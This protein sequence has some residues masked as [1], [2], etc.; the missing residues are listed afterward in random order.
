MIVLLYEVFHAFDYVWLYAV[1]KSRVRDLA[2]LLHVVRMPE[3]HWFVTASDWDKMDD[4]MN[5][6]LAITFPAP[7]QNVP[8]DPRL[9][10]APAG[11]G[12]RIHNADRDGPNGLPYVNGERRDAEN[13]E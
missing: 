1:F 9:E 5:C 7:C 8:I 2:H 6:H 10:T 12:Q 11:P 4:S 3:Q 13:S